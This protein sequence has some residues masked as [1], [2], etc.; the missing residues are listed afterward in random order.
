MNIDI[1]YKGEPYDSLL[2][3]INIFHDR[4]SLEMP[5]IKDFKYMLYSVNSYSEPKRGNH[6]ITKTHMTVLKALG[7]TY[8]GYDPKNFKAEYRYKLIRD[9]INQKKL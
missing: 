5:Y 4:L 7:A 9:S 3:R 8:S 1:W 2:N 6:Y